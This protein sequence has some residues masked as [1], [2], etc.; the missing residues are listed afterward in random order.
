MR[1]KI[2]IGY[3]ADG[4]WSHNAFLKIIQDTRFEIAF[5]VPRYDTKDNILFSFSQKFNIPY[6][7]TQ[8]INSQDF[9]STVKQY[10]CDI[11][12]SMSFNQIFKEPLISIPPLKTINC[13]AGKLPRYRGRNI[14]NWVLINDEKE[15]GITVHYIDS[16]IDT[17][18]IIL[19]RTY[20]ITDDDD[21]S[22]LLSKAY[23][24]CANVLY[25]ALLMFLSNSVA[26]IQQNHQY[27]FYCPMR[28][29]GDEIIDWN[30]TSRS[31]FNFI[32]ALNAPNLGAKSYIKDQEITI[33]KS[34][35]I[36]NAPNYI[37]TSGV[38]VGI[39]K[40]DLIIKTLDSTLRITDY[41][42]KS[43]PKI[44]DRLKKYKEVL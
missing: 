14:L 41:N 15:F 10:Q 3:F 34:K 11:F 1:N 18:D 23:T 37:S 29:Q 8:N 40:N 33:Y 25:D 30:Q 32:R 44:G 38:I 36:N 6:L 2:R 24:E 21:Y 42:Y 19:Q 7:K 39:D 4:I 43:K 16:G 22:S 28:S 13:H 17:G 9:L 12:V 27:G 26:P 31:I 5:I 35:I 20:S